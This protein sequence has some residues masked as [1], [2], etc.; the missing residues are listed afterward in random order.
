[1][2][3]QPVIP[4]VWG[5]MQLFAF[6]GME[7]PTRAW[8]NILASS[9]GDRLGH[10]LHTNRERWNDYGIRLWFATGGAQTLAA[11]DKVRFDAV[12]G[13]LTEAEVRSRGGRFAVRCL[14]LDGPTFGFEVRALEV[15]LGGAT[16]SIEGEL[17]LPGCEVERTGQ[18]L[19]V[20][21]KGECFTAAAGSFHLET[22]A[23]G[24]RGTARL[25]KI[26]DVARLVVRWSDEETPF[27]SAELDVLLK[28]NWG[29][30]ARKRL[31]WVEHL[32]LPAHLPH[33]LEG[34]YRRCLVSLKTN[35]CSPEGAMTVPWTTPD[36]WPHRHCYFWDSAFQSIGYCRIDPEWGKTAL[37]AMWIQQQD[38]G[39][40]YSM[41]H[42]EGHGKTME[43]NSAVMAWTAWEVAVSV[44]GGSPDRAWVAEAYEPLA[45]YMDYCLA[46]R[47]PKYNNLITWESFSHGMDNSPR[48]DG[49]LP[50][51]YPDAN[52][53]VAHDTIF[54]EKMARVLGRDADAE[55]WAAERAS[56]GE[57]INETLWDESL[58]LYCDLMADGSLVRIKHPVSFVA[59]AARTAGPGRTERLL[60]QLLDPRSFNSPMPVATVALDDAAYCTDMWRG[61]MWPNTSY[62]AVRALNEAGLPAEARE[63]ASRI[64]NNAAAWYAKTGGIFEFYDAQDTIHPLEMPRKKGFGAINDYGFSMGVPVALCNWLYG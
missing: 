28:T 51:V 52:L 46:R 58:G 60:K 6:S 3:T 29:L 20:S 40:I 2:N 27:D 48:F 37:R 13:D 19:R 25:Q 61:P 8:K 43:T 30:L 35:A 33:E 9:L 54:L 15:P 18:G 64:V 50:A 47:D 24:F 16:V 53:Y 32:H 5:P 7:G 42:H 12:L 63:M 57:R 26:G 14:M 49:G 45:R 23:A 34:F 31:D 4:H 44:N 22:S 1:M 17:R 38:N 11:F 55:R 62:V 39:F 59:L 21:Y 41:N 10:W 36:R 56:L